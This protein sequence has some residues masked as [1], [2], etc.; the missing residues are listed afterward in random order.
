MPESPRCTAM[1]VFPNRNSCRWYYICLWPPN[2]GTYQKIPIKCPKKD[3]VF[4]N[5]HRKCAHVKDLPKTDACKN[6]LLEDKPVLRFQNPRPQTDNS[7]ID[8]FINVHRNS[9]LANLTKDSVNSISD[10][11]DEPESSDSSIIA[12]APPPSVV[13][14]VAGSGSSGS[15]SVTTTTTASP[16]VPRT[17]TC[18]FTVVFVIYWFPGVVNYAC[19]IA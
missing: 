14:R 16:S 4:S 10:D 1:G 2:Y 12:V 17:Y 19:N 5:T 8:S 7:L 15:S 13:L 6:G 3:E 9:L 11:S 18:P